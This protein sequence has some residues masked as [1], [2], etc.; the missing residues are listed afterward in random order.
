MPTSN[1][2]R[3]FCAAMNLRW[4][5]MAERIYGGEALSWE[6]WVEYRGKGRRYLHETLIPYAAD[7]RVYSAVVVFGRDHTELKLREQEVASQQQQLTVSEALKS[8]IFAT[9]T[10]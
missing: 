5:S 9:Q 3:R 1:P 2:A 6:G 10:G 8:A 7:G 4:A